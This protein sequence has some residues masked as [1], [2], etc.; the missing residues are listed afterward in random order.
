M[1]VY[2]VLKIAW[3]KRRLDVF[4]YAL[5]QV[6]SPTLFEK[7]P[8]QKAFLD[9]DHNSDSGGLFNRRIYLEP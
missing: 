9:S 5:L 6:L 8:I 2:G 1:S 3:K 7:M 4:L